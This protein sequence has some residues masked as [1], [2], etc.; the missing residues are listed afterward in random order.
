MR[1]RVGFE[2]AF[3]GAEGDELAGCPALDAGGEFVF[4]ACGGHVV[5]V[6]WRA[7][8]SGKGARV[9]RMDDSGGGIRR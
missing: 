9:G 5:S 7:H 2:V 3:D 1:L 8:Q 4:V 6:R